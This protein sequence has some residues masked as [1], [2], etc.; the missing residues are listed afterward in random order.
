[1]ADGDDLFAGDGHRRVNDLVGGNDF[2]AA[3]YEVNLAHISIPL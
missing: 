3:D 1:M 2:G